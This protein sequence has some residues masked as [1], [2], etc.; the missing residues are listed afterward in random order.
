MK[1]LSRNNLLIGFLIL[2][3][4]NG[5]EFRSGIFLSI[6]QVV[7]GGILIFLSIDK[8]DV[9]YKSVKFLVLQGLLIFSLI[10]GIYTKWYNAPNH[11][12]L[13]TFITLVI[14][15]SGWNQNIDLIRKNFRWVFVILMGAATIYK[16]I[17]PEFISSD[18]VGFRLIQRL[19]FRPIFA[20]GLFPE[21]NEQLLTNRELIQSALD[22]DPS[23]IS[24]LKAH[25]LK[26]PFEFVAKRFTE[27]IIGGEMI[28]TFMFLVFPWKRIS[29]AFL[30]FFI[31]T[32]GLIVAEYEFASTLL[33][34][35]LIMCPSEFVVIKR[36]YL[37]GFII[38]A[39][40]AVSYN[41]FQILRVYF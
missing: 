2:I 20:A 10:A 28:L 3:V 6:I 8:K 23:I 16:I 15:L 24:S 13:L 4:V 25:E 26:F 5:T 9:N 1:I 17:T 29:L 21:I 38:Y 31:V 39:A 36:G 41:I 11:I 7:L 18:F 32:I 12:F 19:F 30:W 35:G 37:Y 40:I 22:Q 14:I 27:L 34:L 33:F